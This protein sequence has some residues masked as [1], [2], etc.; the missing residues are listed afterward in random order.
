MAIPKTVR[1]FFITSSLYC[2]TETLKAAWSE[3]A[4][5]PL[6]QILTNFFDWFLNNCE[7]IHA[8]LLIF[9]KYIYVLSIFE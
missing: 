6:F 2:I 7:Q 3:A 1:A 5:M 9:N 4:A 8:D